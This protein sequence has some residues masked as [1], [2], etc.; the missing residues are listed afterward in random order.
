MK[1]SPDV[2]LAAAVDDGERAV[3]GKTNERAQ[4]VQVV[5]GEVSKW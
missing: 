5:T 2:V 1:A 3:N 4:S